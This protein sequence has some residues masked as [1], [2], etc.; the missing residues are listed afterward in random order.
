MKLFDAWFAK[1]NPRREEYVFRS[2]P[3]CG[4]FTEQ[5]LR[6]PEQRQTKIPV[7]AL[8]SF[9]VSVSQ[10]KS[11]DGCPEVSGLSF[12]YEGSFFEG[13]HSGKLER[14]IK[15]STIILV[16]PLKTT[17]PYVKAT[18]I[19]GTRFRSGLGI[20]AACGN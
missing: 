17:H 18:E 14:E 7:S 4:G 12:P 6:M 5:L 16:G 2:L 1:R 11:K 15:R 20:R 13:A 10:V 8:W 9:A 19:P 3:W